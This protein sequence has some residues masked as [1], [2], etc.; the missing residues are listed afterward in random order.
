MPNAKDAKQDDIEQSKRF[1][2]LAREIGASESAEA[3][4]LAFKRVTSSTREED[5]PHPSEKQASS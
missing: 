1:I 3:F 5:P 2:E 4:A